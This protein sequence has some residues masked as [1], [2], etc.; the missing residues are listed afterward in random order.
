MRPDTAR[1]W[2]N[3]KN[4]LSLRR[5][6]ASTSSILQHIDLVKR[7][8]RVIRAVVQHASSL[9]RKYSLKNEGLKATKLQR[10]R[11]AE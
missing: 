6:I 7:K 10:V 2:F 4:R 5:K 3:P 8:G 11:K 1:T 9:P